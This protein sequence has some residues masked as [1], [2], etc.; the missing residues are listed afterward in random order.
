M[1]PA[2]S[3]LF[4]RRLFAARPHLAS[5]SQRSRRSAYLPLR[6]LQLEDRL[7]PAAVSWTGGAG[8]LNWGDGPNWSNGAVPTRF[9]DVTIHHAVS[10]SIS[11]GAQAYAAHSLT[12]NSANLVIA[13]GGSLELVAASSLSH[14]L[15][16]NSG[17]SLIVDASAS[18]TLAEGHNL[19][20][21]GTVSFASG[22]SVSLQG[23]FFGS[24]SFNVGS[25]GR[26]L[27]NS[28]T[29]SD[30]GDAYSQLYL[31][32]GNQLQAGDLTGNAFDLPLYLPA[33]GVQYLANNLRF[34]DINI[35]AGTLSNGQIL[36]LDA[37][38]TASTANLRYIFAGNFTVAAGAQVT[39]ASNLNVSLASG[40]TLRDN[41][42]V[43]FS[44]G[45]N[46]SLQGGFFGSTSFIVGSG[47][48]LQANDSTFSDNGDAYSQLYLD[49][50][51]QLQAGDLTGNA[52]NMPLYLPAGG[53][54]YLSNN[55]HFT[56]INILAGALFNTQT[57]AL[58]GIGSSTSPS[59]VFVS[60]GSVSTFTV[61]AGATMTVAPNLSVSL[62]PGVT[63]Q[64]NGAVNFT[65]GDT[66]SINGDFFSGSCSLNVGSGGRLQA[67]GTTFQDTDDRSSRVYLGNGSLLQ[68]GDLVG[69]AFD[70]PLY[71]PA[72]GVRYLTN[73]LRFK[74]IDILPGTLAGGQA[75][76]L[77]TIGTS[78][79]GNQ[80]YVFT[81]DGTARTFT[82][83]AGATVKVASEVQVALASGVTL[84]DNGTVS[85]ASGD[86][87]S[88]Q[89]ATLNVGSGGVLKTAS[90]NFSNVASGSQVEI[91]S[92]GNLQALYSSFD[93]AGLTLDSGSSG[94]LSRDTLGGTGMTLTINS[95]ASFTIA[96]NDLSTFGTASVIAVG[97]STAHINV[98]HNYWGTTDPTGM[99]KDHRTD[100]TRPTF[101][102]SPVLGAV[103]P[104]R[105]APALAA[106]PDQVVTEGSTVSLTASASDSD[107]SVTL[108]YSLD[109][110]APPGAAI[111]PAS[112]LFTYTPDD[113]P[114][115]TTIWVRVTDSNSPPL[116]ALQFFTVTVMNA[117]PTATIQGP[118]DG[119]KGVRGQLRDF[120]V[121]ATDPSQADQAAGFTYDVN[122][123]DGTADTIAHGPG[124]LTGTHV[125]HIFTVAGTY[126]I[127]ATATDKDGGISAP[128]ST[129]ETVVVVE[130][131][132]GT[133]MIGGTPGNDTF[134]LTPG[135]SMNVLAVTV[136]GVSQGTFSTNGE[137]QVLANGGSGD[138]LNFNDQA[139]PTAD[140]Y[141]ITA[142]TVGRTD[143]ATITFSGMAMLNVK[144]GSAANT[145]LV[146]GTAP[147]TT[148][149]LT[150]GGGDNTIVVGSAGNTLDV[151]KGPLIIAGGTGNNML[152]LD[153][154]GSTA[155]S[156][157]IA[158]GTVNRSGAAR[159]TYSNIQGWTLNGS[160][161]ATTITISAGP[162]SPLTIVGGGG[163]TKLVGPNAASTWSVSGANSGTEGKV[164]FSGVTDLK[165]GLGVDTFLILPGGSVSGTIDGGGGKNW[166]DYSAYTDPVSV[167]LSGSAYG[168]LPARS[169]TG[170]GGGG[171]NG[172]ANIL[173]VRAGS[174][175]ATLVGGGGNILV[176]GAGN[177]TLVD[178]YAGTGASGGS[179]LI[180]GSGT[181][182]LTGGKAG[183]LLISGT[184]TFDAQNGSLQDI[185]AYWDTHNHNTAFSALEAGLP[186]THEQLV[187]GT[188]VID[189]A[190]ADVLTGTPNPAAID[191]F[192]AGVGDTI[193]HGKPG[194]DYLN[195]GPE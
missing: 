46:V 5:G 4:A 59:Y 31:D 30:N 119:Y 125:T 136:N 151:V 179:L 78:F 177:N 77:R 53:V 27:A 15:T 191:W 152:S 63:L 71:V 9:D 80:R 26:L 156:Y 111:D 50:G 109:P 102:Y 79:T 185:L 169:A 18:L 22:D 66:V 93:L 3:R 62:V 16:V 167:N 83:A 91:G 81:T 106:I 52:F 28:T 127:T 20:D 132:G 112:G 64:D 166:L 190:G 98:T 58:N 87:V 163:S 108:T 99:F 39:V 14:D 40:I 32:N 188:T 182:S 134:G 157:T 41:G 54:Q 194:T 25:G 153:D 19:Q 162:I 178:R 147:G 137:C 175:D 193:N 65:S 161:G 103:P 44:S 149:K 75:L 68:T 176:G 118:T 148:L 51:S 61:A 92:G 113:G 142:T 121:S 181:D 172:V 128:V 11:I 192:F 73:N 186:T 143:A 67:N 126:T 101:D 48:R 89:T 174:G 110:G 96:N 122:W 72:L 171:A 117:P 105:T 49:N 195:N 154:Q 56:V 155:Q 170:V 36:N 33:G 129:S 158:A 133:L 120:L 42:T 57:L 100:T 85:F 131:Q 107:P 35:I 165:G 94:N 173:N 90:S 135:A 160:G 82:V 6:V 69:N 124:G 1:F 74:D 144:A 146:Q 130:L 97:S 138:V 150:M 140:Q 104:A 10:G 45:D 189:D 159:I 2:S 183:D 43:S 116:S 60:A 38:G 184:T 70:T 23:G 141:L 7:A 114:A 17:A 21:N 55:L 95:G 180:G 12:D 164:T 29:F 88:F 37:I 47:G 24:T 13:A 123:G 76:A 187:W 145:I 139:N 115:V 86:T 84:Q 168:S 8:T 34:R